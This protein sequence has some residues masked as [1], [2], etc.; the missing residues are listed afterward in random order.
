MA[1]QPLQRPKAN[2]QAVSGGGRRAERPH[3]F[4]STQDGLPAL[5]QSGHTQP[6]DLVLEW[7]V[8]LDRLLPTAAA[9]SW[10]LDVL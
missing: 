7:A 9:A 4:R 8:K 10:F 1:L 6:K 3:A 5:G 2:L